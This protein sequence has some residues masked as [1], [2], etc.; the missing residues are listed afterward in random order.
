[1]QACDNTMFMLKQTVIQ[2]CVANLDDKLMIGTGKDLRLKK[3]SLVGPVL[4][5][6]VSQQV[7]SGNQ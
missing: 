2:S 3:S 5:K 7:S 1:M 6:V 4:C